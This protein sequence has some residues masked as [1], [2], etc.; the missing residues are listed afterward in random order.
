MKK[1]IFLF[2]F[3][4]IIALFGTFCFAQEG[5]QEFEGFDLVGYGEGGEKSWD[6]KGDTATIEGDN[7]N[8]VNVD[9]NSYGSENMN[10]VAK[11]GKIDKKS[12]NMLLEKDV[13]VTT[14]QGMQMLTDS[15]NWQKDEDLITTKDEVLILRDN[16]K[17]TGRGVTARPGLNA[18]QLNEDVRVEYEPTA[19][20]STEGTVTITCDGPMEV[21]YENQTAFFSDNVVAIQTDRK[22][23]ADRMELFFDAETKKIKEMICIGNVLI[24]QGEN[25]SFSDRAIYKAQEQKIILSGRPKLL[26]YLEEDKGSDVSFGN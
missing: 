2:I 24:V 17:A 11:T 3:F 1:N 8:I 10:V 12:G 22:L 4:S 18:A 26:M 13:V 9:A 19:Q 16:M 23:V 6:L 5:A 25:T 14:E 15:L 7:V 20:E 21:D